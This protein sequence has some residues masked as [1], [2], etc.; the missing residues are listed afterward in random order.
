ME[1][2]GDVIK[3]L[4]P[5]QFPRIVIIRRGHS[6]TALKRVGVDGKDEGARK[7]SGATMQIALGYM[8][9]LG[10]QGERRTKALNDQQSG[11]G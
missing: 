6:S 3:T 9:R 2:S 11:V 10:L 5:V 8:V 7:K 1:M 4:T